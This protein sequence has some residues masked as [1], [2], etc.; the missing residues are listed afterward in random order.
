MG[1]T[2][3]HLRG[4]DSGFQA[5]RVM[6]ASLTLPSGKDQ[7]R[8]AAIPGVDCAASND[9]PP[10]GGSTWTTSYVVKACLA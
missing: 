5:D 1:R 3:W 10:F 4:V 8:F 9:T 6:E 2:L 7:D